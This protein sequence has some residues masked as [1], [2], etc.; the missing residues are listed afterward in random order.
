MPNFSKVLIEIFLPIAPRSLLDPSS[1]VFHQLSKLM[2]KHSVI[3]AGIPISFKIE[4]ITPYGRIL[5]DGSV[6]VNTLV[7]LCVLKI[8]PG[9]HVE[10]ND[11]LYAGIFPCEVDGDDCYSGGL[12]VKSISGAG[13]IAGTN[14]SEDEF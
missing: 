4:G 7:E 1:C 13:K 11:G 5:D 12:R 2:L 8:S 3:L 14:L 10:S 6:Y 9:D